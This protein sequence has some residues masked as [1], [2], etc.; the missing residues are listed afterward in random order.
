MATKRAPDIR[1]KILEV[2]AEKGIDTKKIFFNG[3]DVTNT[4]S[5]ERGGLQRYMRNESPFSK[6]INC[7][8]HRFALVFKHLMT[9]YQVV[10]SLDSLLLQLWKTFKFSTNNKAVLDEIQKGE[11]KTNTLKMLKACV[12][13]WLTHGKTT[14]RVSEMFVEIVDSF[15]NIFAKTH[16][17]EIAGI[18]E[19]L[20]KPEMILFNLFMADILHICNNFCKYLQ[21]RNVRFS[22]LP[23]KVK[24][25]K[26]KIIS[27]LESP[28]Q[29]FE[30]SVYIEHSDNY[31]DISN[32][33]RQYSTRTRNKAESDEKTNKELKTDFWI[34][35]AT[36]FVTDLLAEIDEAF[37]TT[38]D[39]ILNSFEVFNPSNLSKNLTDLKN[40]FEPHVNV[41]GNF[42]SNDKIDT[43]RERSTTVEKIINAQ[44]LND[45]LVDFLE[46][47]HF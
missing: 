19:T 5:G 42:Y 12:I 34:N 4:M 3:F 14:K 1:D 8:S 45:E 18:R 43:F 30:K 22:S 10:N 39:E 32:H 17:P 41:L 15:D 16:D 24:N 6:Y 9:R 26:E 33:Q 36:P 31:L 27:Y 23:S 44:S 13:R 21:G 2:F 37:S 11:G 7:R 25:L 38:S 35:T 29:A 28:E 20:L 46:T 47:R 40:H